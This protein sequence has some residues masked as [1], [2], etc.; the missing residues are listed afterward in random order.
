MQAKIT[1]QYRPLVIKQHVR[2]CFTAYELRDQDVGLDFNKE[3]VSRVNSMCNDDMSTQ[4]KW[5]V[6]FD[7]YVAGIE[8]V[9]GEDCHLQPDW[10]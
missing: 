3:A 1:L 10:F 6:L 4:E 2:C 9:L 7:R 5:K 8:V